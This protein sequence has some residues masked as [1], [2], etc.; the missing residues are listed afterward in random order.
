MG[1]GGCGSGM[2]LLKDGGGSDGGGGGTK[3]LNEGGSGGGGGG[4]GGCKII[5]LLKTRLDYA[6]NLKS[7]M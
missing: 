2:K 7:G 5:S 3:F 4:G 6:G 1:S